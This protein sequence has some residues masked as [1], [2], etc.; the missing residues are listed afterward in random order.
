MAL[1]KFIPQ[2]LMECQKESIENIT[3][4]DANFAPAF[5][6]HHSLPDINSNGHCLTKNNISIPKK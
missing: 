4:S 1:L 6:D 3:K 5:V 2:N